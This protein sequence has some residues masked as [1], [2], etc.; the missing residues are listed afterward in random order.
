MGLLK[1]KKI[2]EYF[3]D[4]IYKCLP[5]EI[6]GNGALLV[7]LG[8]NHSNITPWICR[9]T[10]FYNFLKN[11]YQFKLT[12]ISFDFA[13]GNIKG[14]NNVFSDN[15]GIIAIPCLFHLSQ[16]WWRKLIK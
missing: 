2:S 12:K 4:C 10:E 3:I 6:K 1:S 13:L 11:S 15:D 16:S 8:Y 7:L 14:L 9:H 5:H